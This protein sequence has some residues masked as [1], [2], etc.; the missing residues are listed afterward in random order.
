MAGE[1]ST[2]FSSQL[3][4]LI[5]NG[6]TIPNLAINATSGPLTSL[7]VSLHTADPTASG[8]QTTNEVAYTGYARVAVV[9]TSS[10]WLVTGASVS[11]V[12]SVIFPTPTGAATQVATNWAVGVASSGASTIL[13][14]GSISPSIAITIGLPPTL[15]AATTVTES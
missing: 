5:F 11:P 15:T 2:T 14:T 10:G 6:T 8:N 13:Y 9:R 4:A 3:L 12:G 1:K 7:F